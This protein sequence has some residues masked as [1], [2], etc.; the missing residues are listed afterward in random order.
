VEAQGP[1][2]SE[3][4]PTCTEHVRTPPAR[5]PTC[6]E[7]FSLQLAPA[8]NVRRIGSS[9]VYE[10]QWMRVREDQIERADG[11]RG[12]YGVVEKDDFALIV[13][14]DEDGGLWIVEQYRYPVAAR[15]WEFP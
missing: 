10:N 11:S 6:R 4:T 12:I 15:C 8:M 5:L 9:L 14:R 7:R 3:I 13:P 1:D 2:G